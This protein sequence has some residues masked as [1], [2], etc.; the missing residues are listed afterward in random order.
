MKAPLVALAATAA[1]FAAASAY[2]YGE[3]GVERVLTQAEVAARSK[4]E[5]R[6]KQIQ[7]SG[8]DAQASVLPFSQME[9]SS[10]VESQ[11]AP[12]RLSMEGPSRPPPSAGPT[13]GTADTESK[14]PSQPDPKRPSEVLLTSERI[15]PNAPGTT[16]SAVFTAEDRDTA[17]R[18]ARRLMRERESNSR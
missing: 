17:P 9:T 11:P 14:L 12:P 16:V 2:L 13:L 1:G 6:I 3:L 4:H 10:F 15:A 7:T 18:I 5:S 8:V